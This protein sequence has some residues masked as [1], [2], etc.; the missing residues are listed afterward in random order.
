MKKRN[1]KDKKK[2]RT[3]EEKTAGFFVGSNTLEQSQRI[4]AA[5][6]YARRESWWR[7]K[8]INGNNFLE[9]GGDGA[10][11]VPENRSKVWEFLSLL[12]ELQQ[13]SFSFICVR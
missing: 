6:G 11:G 4:A 13:G 7:Q 9:E 8:R 1:K 2:G 12:A 3:I 5:V 10:E